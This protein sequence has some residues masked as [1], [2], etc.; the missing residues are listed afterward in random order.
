MAN[1]L[2]FI[3]NDYLVKRA[4]RKRRVGGHVS[5]GEIE[6]ALRMI[7]S[8]STLIHPISLLG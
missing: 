2:S 3:L 5:Q 8:D 4:V 7:V 6:A 1:L